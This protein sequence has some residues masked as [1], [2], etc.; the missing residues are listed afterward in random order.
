MQFVS[1]ALVITLVVMTTASFGDDAFAPTGAKASLS[2]DYVYE[3]VGK[4]RS[5]GMY[6]PYEW[7]VKRSA[8]LVAEL[9]AQPATAMPTLQA[10][11]ASQ[12]AEL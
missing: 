12:M 11:D 10:I 4:K 8:N 6:D 1:S 9:A 5:E 2:V 3:S 7:R